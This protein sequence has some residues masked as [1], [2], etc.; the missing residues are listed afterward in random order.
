MGIKLIGT[1][2]TKR[3]EY[4][5]KAAK[6]LHIPFEFV[7]WK[8]IWRMDFQG[9]VLKIDPPAYETTNL[10]EMNEQIEKFVE[11]MKVL[12]GK[13][14]DFLN[15]PAEILRVL[16]KR[17]CKEILQKN[18]VPVT[19]MF[20][21]QIET[22][23]QLFEA[24]NK[25]RISSVF[26]KPVFCSGAAGVTA[27]RLA[28][29][30]GKMVAYTSCLLKD[31]EL[32]NTKRLRRLEK[33]E[34]IYP[35]LEAVLSLGVIV[36]RW[37]PKAVFKGKSYDLRV[38]WQFG[39]C[40]FIVAR[41]SSGPV[42]NLHLNN[43]PLAF[44]ELGLSS[45]TIKEIESVCER[46]MACFPKLKMAGIDVLLEKDSLQPRVIEVNGQGDLMY[47]DIFHENRI[48]KRQ[49][50]MMSK[51]DMNEIVGNYNILFV[52]ID[53][54]RYDV[55][56]QEQDNGGTPNLN[57][58]GKW[59]KCQ[60]PGNFTYPSHQAMFAGF[61][62]VDADVKD[63]KKREKLFFS[64]DIGM[65]RKAPEGSFC[66]QGATF[67]EGLAKVGYETMCVGG[68]SF[69]DKRT[70]IGK[71]MPGYFNQSYWHPSFG[72]KVKDSVKNQ[73]DF[74]VKK[75]NELPK[76]QLLMMYIN[77]SAIHY[78][79]YFYVD[80]AKK[81]SVESHAAALRFVDEELDKLFTAFQ[82]KGET[83]VICCSDHGTCYGE[84]GYLYHGFNHPIVNT[85]PY[86][87][88]IL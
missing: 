83:F 82:N 12:E 26:I 22:V 15:P 78:P 64:E 65:G 31:N 9:D 41:Q 11:Q 42:T 67:V 61:F 49:V 19:E 10:F 30:S 37:H 66:F 34:E 35:L 32:I 55:A 39:K 59:R 76:E 88:F 80:G 44:S 73:V 86:K 52:C 75:V 51:I 53:S 69:F 81:D 24:M 28:Q 79:N 50:E 58:Y 45:E 6:E 68:L 62:P 3:T 70:D 87:H 56:K 27:F 47:Q 20:S 25:H 60:A 40:E 16:N 7:D 48:Y 63:M 33:P 21:E 57:R 1:P 71:V 23:E 54:L 38:V 84:D 18:Q 74:A 36:E 8:N 46:T 2:Q 13:D 43:A 85:V 77:I 29:K 72:P 4:F 14:C 5:E 17:T